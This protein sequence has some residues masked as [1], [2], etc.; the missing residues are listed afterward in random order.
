MVSLVL[1]MKYADRQVD[2]LFIIKLNFIKIK[3]MDQ[4]VVR[5]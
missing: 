2:G 3:Q 1:D 5:T 4:G